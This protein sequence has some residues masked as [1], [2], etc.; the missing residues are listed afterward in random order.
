MAKVGVFFGSNTGNTRKVAKFIKRGFDDELMA[1]PVNVNRVEVEDFAQY[2]FLILGTPTLGS[3]EL[4]GLSSDCEAESWEEFLPKIEHLDFSGKTVALFALGD[5]VG[6]PDEFVDAMIE[7][8]DFVE[9]RGA[10]IVG[11]WPT[12]GYD[13]E[14]SESVVDDKFVGLVLDQDNQSHLTEQRLA[15]WLK[16]IAEDFSLPL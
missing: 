12:D 1:K 5:Q 9:E 13:F 8:Y 7:I 2:D 16:Q 3:G 4:P 11:A 15:T 14:S 10:T 6:Y